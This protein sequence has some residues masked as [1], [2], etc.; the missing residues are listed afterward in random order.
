MLNSCI[1][2]ELEYAATVWSH[3]KDQ[4]AT[5]ESVLKLAMCVCF[6]KWD[7]NYHTLL[8]MNNVPNLS[9][10]RLFLCLSFLFNEYTV[11]HKMHLLRVHCNNALVILTFLFVI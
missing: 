4:T 8:S 9:K 10:R 7:I 5:L 2:P 11:C 3:L 1:R 6:R